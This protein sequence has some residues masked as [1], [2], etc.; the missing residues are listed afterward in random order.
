VLAGL[1]RPAAA[2]VVA[3]VSPA[4]ARRDVGRGALVTVVRRPDQ[5]RARRLAPPIGIEYVL[6]PLSAYLACIIT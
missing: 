4:I 3:V 6:D 1:W 2:Q 5:P